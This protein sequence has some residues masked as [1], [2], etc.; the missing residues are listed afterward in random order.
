MMILTEGWGFVWLT[1]FNI[2]ICLVLPRLISS[3]G[4]EASENLKPQKSQKFLDSETL[5][6]NG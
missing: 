6:E 4:L 2:T 5:P 1:L 3:K